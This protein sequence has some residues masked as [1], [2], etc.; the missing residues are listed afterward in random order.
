MDISLFGDT[1]PVISEDGCSNSSSTNVVWHSW[2]MTATSEF[3]PLSLADHFLLSS[4]SSSY[5][6]PFLFHK[7]ELS[8]FQSDSNAEY[9]LDVS[10]DELEWALKKVQGSSAGPFLSF[11]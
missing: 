1:S 4:S 11:D 7:A 5:C 6:D 8:S 10:Y 2:M 9:N 3:A